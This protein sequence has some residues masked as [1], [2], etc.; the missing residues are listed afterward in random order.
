MS[1]DAPVSTGRLILV[2]AVI[3]LAV[4]LLR[5]FGELQGWSPRL[6]S[7]EAGGAFA[8]VGIWWLVPVFGAWFGWTIARSGATPR[9]V[10]AVGFTLLAIAAL[11][12]ALFAARAAGASEMGT[13]TLASMAVGSI[14]GLLLAFAAWP[15][16]GRTLLAYALAARIP[17][18]LVMLFAILGSWGTHYDVAPPGL[19]A[20]APL[21]KWVLIGLVPQ[22]TFWIWYTLV[23]G[24][25]FGLGA[26]ALAR[27]GATA[28]ATA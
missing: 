21:P 9:F 13:G 24:T 17:V 10:R 6:F 7:R 16:L 27:R 11:V 2:P 14:V 3:T 1:D 25:L 28:T 15:A 12:L 5:L 26:A 8:L 19:Q 22:M 20:M 23:F 4:T 18:A